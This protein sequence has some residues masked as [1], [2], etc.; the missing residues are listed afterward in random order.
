LIGFAGA[1]RA[2][3]T[4]NS[5]S[6]GT[7]AASVGAGFRYLMARR[8]GLYVGLDVAKSNYDHAFY[9]QVGNAWR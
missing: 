1:G 9:I 7:K 8:L 5:F 4:S 6:D 3:G 2:W